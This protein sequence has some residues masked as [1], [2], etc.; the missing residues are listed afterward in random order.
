MK[1]VILIAA[2]LL[3]AGTVLASDPNSM[4][5]PKKN[6][7]TYCIDESHKTFTIRIDMSGMDRWY[8]ARSK[9]FRKELA[10][11]VSNIPKLIIE[12]KKLGAI[13]WMNRQTLEQTEVERTR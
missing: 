12:L 2:I 13:E 3:M 9:V 4:A 7:Y 10:S 6:S 5:N 11:F 1:Q 8:L